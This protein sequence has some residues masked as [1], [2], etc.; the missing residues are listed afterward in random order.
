MLLRVLSPMS[1]PF[2]NVSASSRVL[3]E[4]PGPLRAGGGGSRPSPDAGKKPLPDL[5]QL[6]CERRA[7]SSAECAEALALLTAFN[8]SLW[9]QP[10]LSAFRKTLRAYAGQA[11]V[12]RLSK[13][14]VHLSVRS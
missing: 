1:E 4:T 12:S 14:M 3:P 8:A 9:D 2:C 7:T 6:N 13:R 11:Q 10:C 5:S